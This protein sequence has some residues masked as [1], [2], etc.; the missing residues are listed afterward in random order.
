MRLPWGEESFGELLARYRTQ[1][2]VSRDKLAACLKVHRNTVVKW[3]QGN[4]L[5]KDRTRIEGIVRCLNLRDPQRNALLRAAL[6]ETS[7]HDIPP[8]VVSPTGMPRAVSF[9]GRERERAQLLQMLQADTNTGVFALA[10]IGGVGKTALAAE[11]MAELAVDKKTFPGGAAWIAC[12]D[13][14]GEVG[15]AGLWSRVARTLGFPQVAA[16]PDPQQQCDALRTALMDRQHLLLGLDNV[17]GLNAGAILDTL[18]IQGH[19]T[20]LLTAWQRFTPYRLPAIELRPLEP[21]DARMLFV[22]RL[23]QLDTTRPTQQ[24]EAA[25]PRL[26]D[27]MG[28]LPLAIGITAAYAGMQG[29]ALETLVQNIEAAGIRADSFRDIASPEAQLALHACFDRSWQKLSERQQRLFASLSLLVGPSFPRAAA[30]ALAEATPEETDPPD[31]QTSPAVDL[32]RLL[33]SALVEPIPGERYRLHPHLRDY[34]AERLTTLTAAQQQRLGEAMLAFWLEYSEAHPG[35]EGMD[36]LEAEAL[37][38]IGALDWAR[39][40]IP[41]VNL[42]AL[43]HALGPTSYVLLGGHEEIPSQVVQALVTLGSYHWIA[44]QVARNLHREGRLEGARSSYEDALHTAQRMHNLK[45]E[46]EDVHDLASLDWQMGRFT[47]AQR[48]FER[49]LELAR[50]L[51][52]SEAEVQELQALADLMEELS[53]PEQERKIIYLKTEFYRVYRLALLDDLRG[54]FVSAHIGFERALELARQLED[55]ENAREVIHDLAS[56][57]WQIG[58]LTEARSGFERALEL[59]RQLSDS[60]AE[61]LELRALAGL[62]AELNDPEQEREAYAR[63]RDYLKSV[64]RSVRRLALLHNQ[65]GH[66]ADA[67]RGFERAL[68]LA[69][70]LGDSELEA[71]GLRTLGGFIGQLNEPEQGR[72]LIKQSL[73]ICE[74][75]NDTQG[76]GDCYQYLAWVDGPK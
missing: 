3:E 42:I 40:H 41:D 53:E 48:G 50:Q 64:L 55:S 69:R 52:D 10:G 57:D 37:G 65:K 25:L 7:V 11:V 71:Q 68:E 75:L 38:R 33:A 31:I 34:A 70:Q 18:V 56:L 24:D 14:T 28:G 72:E 61:S 47:E 16:L 66:F 9:V 35:H 46:R 29:L 20:L 4:S 63:A 45:Y 30:L 59:A 27:L 1:S 76:I 49:A 17:D 39:D 67:R 6:L 21:P 19:T 51:G 2:R 26:L 13:L 58:R 5:P 62:L 15:L 22:Q 73:A 8:L 12:E 54:H 43:G 74:R 60:E 44:R 36:E 32:A 23:Q